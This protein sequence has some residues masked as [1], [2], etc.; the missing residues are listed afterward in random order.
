M[1]V[2]ECEI[3][4]CDLPRISSGKPWCKGHTTRVRKT[5]D[6]G[7]VELRHV[8]PPRPVLCCIVGCGWGIYSKGM[9]LNHW[10]HWTK[11]GDP[12]HDEP[13][14]SRPGPAHP[15][16]RGDDIT[17]VQAHQR[18]RKAKGRARDHACESCHGPA[19]HWAY[20]HADPNEKHDEN[21]QAYSANDDHYRPL[22]VPCHK[23]SDLERLGGQAPR[24]SRKRAS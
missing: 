18:V 17:Y 5:G 19:L 13:T 7:S 23:R 9:S 11:H 10:R 14:G 12:L 1:I 16:W 3:E 8:G 4:G 22:C 6:P 2:H 21:G 24:H 20:D 15:Q